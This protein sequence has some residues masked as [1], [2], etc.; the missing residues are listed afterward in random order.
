MFLPTLTEL[1]LR[2]IIQG[3]PSSLSRLRATFPLKPNWGVMVRVVFVLCPA[4]TLKV[5]GFRLMLKSGLGFSKR[6]ELTPPKPPPQEDTSKATV[7][8]NKLY[9]TLT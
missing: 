1:G 6:E 4:C 8:I 9:I 5:L 2:P 7:R 3:L